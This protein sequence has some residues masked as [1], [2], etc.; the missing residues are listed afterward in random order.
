M[1]DTSL[2]KI[3]AATAPEGKLGQRYLASG[4]QVAM[5]MWHREAAGEADETH[6]RDYETV[7]PMSSRDGPNSPSPAR[8]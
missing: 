1:S 8:R 6:A 2:K 3:Q 7:G 4:K 5:R